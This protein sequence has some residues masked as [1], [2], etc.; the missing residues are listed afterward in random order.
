MDYYT[1]IRYDLKEYLMILRHGNDTVK[2]NVVYIIGIFIDKFSVYF[3]KMKKRGGREVRLA[4]SVGRACDS[5]SQSHE[6][7]PHVGHGVCF[8]K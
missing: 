8:K 5:G 1:A 7:K 4:G 3:L 6:F 2:W